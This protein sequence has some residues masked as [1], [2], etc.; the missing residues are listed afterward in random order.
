MFWVSF[1]LFNL[2]DLLDILLDTVVVQSPALCHFRQIPLPN[3]KNKNKTQNTRV[4]EDTFSSL[5][6]SLTTKQNSSLWLSGSLL[7][8]ELAKAHSSELAP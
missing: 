1:F 7:R 3:V 2:A 6:M 8:S 4:L 5:K